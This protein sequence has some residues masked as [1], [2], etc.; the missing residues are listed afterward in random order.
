VWLLPFIYTYNPCLV[1]EKKRK[2]SGQRKEEVKKNKNSP[3]DYF[4]A[5]VLWPVV[6]FQTPPIPVD[7]FDWWGTT[8]LF[9]LLTQVSLIKLR[10]S[11]PFVRVGT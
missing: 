8:V 7:L 4:L 10:I 2:K 9:I 6:G 5:N 1:Y 11:L 3:K